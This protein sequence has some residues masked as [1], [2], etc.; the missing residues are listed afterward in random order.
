VVSAGLLDNVHARDLARAVVDDGK[1]AN[2]A[3]AVA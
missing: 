2:A 1:Q 3:A